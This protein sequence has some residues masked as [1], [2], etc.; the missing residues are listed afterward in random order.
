[1]NVFSSLVRG[2]WFPTS[3]PADKN[4][5]WVETAAESDSTSDPSDGLLDALGDISALMEEDDLGGATQEETALVPVEAINTQTSGVYAGEVI[6]SH[7][8]G[9]PRPLHVLRAKSG[10]LPKEFAKAFGPFSCIAEC[11]AAVVA[12][13][14]YTFGLRKGNLTSGAFG[15]KTGHGIRRVLKCVNP[16]KIR[17]PFRAIFELVRDEDRHVWYMYACSSHH[18]NHRMA[19]TEVEKLTLACN[20]N[21]PENYVE[22]AQ[23][24]RAVGNTPRQVFEFLLQ[25]AKEDGISAMFTLSDVQNKLRPHPL[26]KITDSNDV[27]NM[28]KTRERD[29]DLKYSIRLSNEGRLEM[30]FTEMKNARSILKDAGANVCVQFDTT[31]GTNVHECKVGLFTIV[32]KHLTTRILATSLIAGDE[33]TEKMEWV[34]TEFKACFGL[35]PTVI[36]TDSCS[37]I[38]AAV[39]SVF[40]LSN[41]YLCLWHIFLNFESHIYN[42]V[43][44]VAWKAI[45]Q[46]FWVIAKETDILSVDSF[47]REFQEL[48]DLVKTAV[49]DNA[50]PD[51]SKKVSNALAWLQDT[52]YA[53]RMKWAYRY[54]WQV[55]TAGCHSTQRAESIHSAIKTV[56]AS[57]NNSLLQL[58]NTLFS[59]EDGK[60]LADAINLQIATKRKGDCLRGAIIDSVKKLSISKQ[61]LQCF[62]NQYCN[63]DYYCSQPVLD[64]EGNLT[65]WNVHRQSNPSLPVSEDMS[66]SAIE[67]GIDED[68]SNTTNFGKIHFVSTTG[69]CTCQFRTSWGIACRHVIHVSTVVQHKDSSGVLAVIGGSLTNY[70]LPS[71]YTPTTTSSASATSA[72]LLQKP[73]STNNS[74]NDEDYKE[75]CAMMA[76]LQQFMQQ[77]QSSLPTIK[78]AL[79][80]IIGAVGAPLNCVVANPARPQ[81]KPGRKP[82]ARFP[83]QHDHM[84]SK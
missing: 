38:G 2:I 9:R 51:R 1:M 29:S 57:A 39:G 50:A 8:F 79:T 49:G 41:H 34:L 71:T 31:H 24:L 43:P 18:C 32:S 4:V 27:V 5:A 62:E 84:K 68:V 26:D 55:F 35:T 33:N 53:K 7:K 66:T 14:Q 30:I 58:F 63:K 36:I 37:K 16:D 77:H 22:I 65:G 78:K 17:C 13:S 25:S 3:S 69:V 74:T 82:K 83:N 52:L 6:D 11:R 45:N 67:L 19:E 42:I 64:T 15:V 72:N 81:N 48:V 60:T 75:C 61:V 56:L 47:D 20:R 10:S 44:N 54:T 73:S 21:I 59:Y 80:E 23:R 12:C 70:W 46:K 40:P 28:L 76:N